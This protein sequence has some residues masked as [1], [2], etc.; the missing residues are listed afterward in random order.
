[1]KQRTRW[2]LLGIGFLGTAVIVLA[3]VMVVL[4]GYVSDAMHGTGNLSRAALT[5]LFGACLALLRFGSVLF[6]RS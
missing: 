2:A 5:L 6:R 1:M 4:E 3:V